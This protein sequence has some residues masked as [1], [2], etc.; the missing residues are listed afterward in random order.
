VQLIDLLLPI[1][2][3]VT[4]V[5]IGGVIAIVVKQRRAIEP[6]LRQVQE[7][8]AGGRH[9]VEVDEGSAWDPLSPL[10]RLVASGG[11]SEKLRRDL[12]KAGFFSESAAAVYM[13]LKM[14]MLVI[15][16]VGGASVVLL[17]ELTLPVK[18]TIV[19]IASGL[20][21]FIP[22]IGLDIL[23]RNRSNEI[24]TYLPDAVDLLEVCV[25]SGMGLDMAWN[26]VTDEIRSVSVV[27]ADEMALT[28]LEM[29]LGAARSAALRHMAE[30]T[31]SDELSSLVAMLVQSDRFG[32]S[33]GDT[34]RSFAL[35]MREN[36]TQRAEE[37]AEKMAVK[38]LFPMVLFIFPV[39]MIITVGPAGIAIFRMISDN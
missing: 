19:L 29:Q 37:A 9:P 17:T 21:F 15:A 14:L 23:R 38:L 7:P 4:V 13:G 6:R 18:F 32:T 3:F 31:G 20:L 10:G 35:S 30:R 34:L 16:L 25:S 2:I 12:A 26:A 1:L 36:R 33:I 28:N 24:R 22:N 27:L 39:M 8:V 5:S 11:A